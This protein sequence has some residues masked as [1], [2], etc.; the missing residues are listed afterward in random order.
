MQE[1]PRFKWLGFR[2]LH[3]KSFSDFIHNDNDAEE[4][5]VLQFV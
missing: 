5:R 4:V 1:F 2:T 3:Y